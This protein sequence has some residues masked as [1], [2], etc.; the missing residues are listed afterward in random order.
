M[1]S[2]SAAMTKCS[3]EHEVILVGLRLGSLTT[4]FN[5]FLL[6]PLGRDPEVAGFSKSPEEIFGANIIAFKMEYAMSTMFYFNY[7]QH[8]LREEVNEMEKDLKHQLLEVVIAIY[9]MRKFNTK[10]FNDLM[11]DQVELRSRPLLAKIFHQWTMKLKMFDEKV[12][13]FITSPHFSKDLSFRRRNN[14]AYELIFGTIEGIETTRLI[15]KLLGEDAVALLHAA[16]VYMT[17]GAIRHVV[18]EMKMGKNVGKNNLDDYWVSI[19]ENWADANKEYNRECV[20]HNLKIQICLLK[21]CK[22]LRRMVEAMY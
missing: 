17:R 11:S 18:G 16:E 13:N 3:S 4:L 10:Y 14:I 6:E 8:Y 19:L 20:R 2:T 15:P 7:K 5:Q 12:T 21:M 9:K 22:Y 1:L